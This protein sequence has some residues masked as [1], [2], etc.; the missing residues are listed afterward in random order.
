VEG[1]PA[2][3]VAVTANYL[4]PTVTVQMVEQRRDVPLFYAVGEADLNRARMR[5]G[6]HLLRGA[7][8]RVTVRRPPIGHVL[9]RHIGQAALD[10]FASV[11]RKAAHRQLEN[12]RQ[13]AEAGDEVY[14]GPAAAGLEDI[15]RQRRTHF[16]DQIA[17]AADLLKQLQ[18]PA[19]S[20]LTE[21]AR[22]VDCNK[23][24]KARELLLDVEQR[25]HPSTL[26]AVARQ[27]RLDVEA[28]PGVAQGLA[29]ME[30]EEARRRAAD[31]WQA[32]LLALADARIEE[33]RRHCRNLLALYPSSEPAA[34]ARLVLQKLQAASDRP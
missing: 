23:P 17:R 26:A 34:E 24:L 22:L 7:G 32:A 27:R 31:L 18:Q 33:A 28:L 12:A 2:T 16:P 6:L 20:A 21:A 14:A 29:A 9:S 1:F 30:R 10:W 15:L 4:P 19:N 11:C 3:A 25:Y 5:E 13:I 8:A